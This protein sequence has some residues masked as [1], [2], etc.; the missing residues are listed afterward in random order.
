MTTLESCRFRHQ[1]TIRSDAKS[2]LQKVFTGKIRSK[3]RMG[4]LYRMLTLANAL[5]HLAIF[6]GCGCSQALYSVEPLDGRLKRYHS[7]DDHQRRIFRDAVQRSGLGRRIT[8]HD[9]RRAAATHLHLSGL[10]L[11]RLQAILGHNSLEVTQLYIL[12]DE[13]EINGAHSPFDQLIGVE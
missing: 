11:K 8:P 12:E 1:S 5:P 2:G 9:V 10:P 6:V 13:S 7:A 3:I 4:S